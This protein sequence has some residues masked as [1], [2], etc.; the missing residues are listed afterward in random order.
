VEDYAL[1]LDASGPVRLGLLANGFPDSEPFLDRLEKSLSTRLPQA[2]FVRF[3]KYNASAQVTNE[4]RDE[5]VE[6]CDAVIA[7]YGH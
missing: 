4:M 6:R 7:A 3:N 5:A 1:Q 2:S